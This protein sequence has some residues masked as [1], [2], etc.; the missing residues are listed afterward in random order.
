M[1]LTIRPTVK[2]GVVIF[3]NEIVRQRRV[4]EL[5]DVEILLYQI[6]VTF[7]ILSSVPVS[8]RPRTMLSKTSHGFTHSPQLFVCLIVFLPVDF[9]TH[10]HTTSL[11]VLTIDIEDSNCQSVSDYAFVVS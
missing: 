1:W 6:V 9:S 8:L 11:I 3:L 4:E 7:V 5:V 2:L 10:P